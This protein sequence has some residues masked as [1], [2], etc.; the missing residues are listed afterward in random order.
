MEEIKGNIKA[1]DK[2]TVHRICSGQVVLSLAIAVKELVENSIDAGA[3]VV[4]VKLKDYGMEHVEVSDNGHGV[5]PDNFEGLTLKH[6]TSKLRDFSDLIGVD[7]Y[8]FRG[9]ALSSLCALSELS[10]ITRHN[11]VGC[12]T[13]LIFDRNGLIIQQKQC[14]RQVGTTVNLSNLFSSLPVRHKEFHKNI[15]REFNKMIQLLYA[16]CLISTGIK[17]TCTNQTKKGSKTTF[18]ATHG[19]KSIKEN[20]SSVFGSKQLSSLLEINQCEPSEDILKELNF[21]VEDCKVFNI[22]GYISSCAHGMGRSTNDRQFYFINSRPCEPSKII[23]AVNEIYHQFNVHQ[24]PFVYMNITVE[25]ESVDVN[26]TPDKRQI[27]LNHEKLLIAIVKAS[28]LS[29]FKSIPSTYGMNNV[30]KKFES[31]QSNLK[32]VEEDISVK[33]TSISMFSQWRSVADNKRRS[34]TEPE[35]VDSKKCKLTNNKPKQCSQQPTLHLFNVNKNPLNSEEQ[36][37]ISDSKNKQSD[38][39]SELPKNEISEKFEETDV[40][41]LVVNELHSNEDLKMENTVEMSKV[42]NTEN[43]TV[44]IHSKETEVDSTVINESHCTDG[45]TENCDSSNQNIFD[46]AVEFVDEGV[47][48]ENYDDQIDFVSN[49]ESEDIITSQ[50]SGIE[51][52]TSETHRKPNYDTYVERN[53]KVIVLPI[54]LDNIKTMMEKRINFMKNTNNS[55]AFTPNLRFR[56]AIDPSKNELA[57]KEL[58]KEITKD[59]F[60]EMKII[61]QFNLGFIIS[62][63]NSDLFIIDQHATDEKYNFETLQKTTVISNQKLV[64]PQ[65]LELTAANENILIDNIDIF[66]K[67][68]FDFKIDEEAAPTKR[69]SLTAIPMSRNWVFGKEDVDEL[70]FMLE[71]SPQT[72]CRPSRIRSMFA[73]R[74]CR[75]SVM[76]GRALNMQEMKRLVRHMGEIEHPWN[77]PHGRPTMRHL[78]NLDL[79]RY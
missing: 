58:S 50:E 53:K 64:V 70:I 5:H 15:K 59:M 16:Y 35:I 24:T 71:D 8:G 78:I 9:E 2:T 45:H 12:G 43:I 18:V 20:I 44:T 54:N 52:D 6:H 32:K 19:C 23:K 33:K 4:D 49:S 40:E 55:K 1:I 67:N 60:S 17:I 10:I 25:K 74:A 66:K 41:S 3:T 47:T 63:L 56:A 65:K 48:S 39:I 69:I 37:K 27:F 13:E 72:D 30:P 76:I 62:K 51:I 28:L 75:K 34:V 61:G 77:C 7:T 79:V 29:T 22:D 57:E 26:V 11:S 68:G 14:A 46:S 42:S 38:E 73:S 36:K 21:S 31:S